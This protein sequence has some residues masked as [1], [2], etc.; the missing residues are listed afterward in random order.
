MNF[1]TINIVVG[2]L[3]MQTFA[4]SVTTVCTDVSLTGP[5]QLFSSSGRA[6]FNDELSVADANPNLQVW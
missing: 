6:H 4:N 5:C 1:V 2:A 3:L